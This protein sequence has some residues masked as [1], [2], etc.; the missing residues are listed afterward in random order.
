MMSGYITMSK[1]EQPKKP[2]I[3]FP[4][5]DYHIS[6]VADT[7]DG[8]VTILEEIV[9]RHCGGYQADRLRVI[10]SKMGNIK[11]DFQSPLKAKSN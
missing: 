1:E 8:F 7:H 9:G 10:A 3:Q 4:C 11:V 2:M 6:V 5:E